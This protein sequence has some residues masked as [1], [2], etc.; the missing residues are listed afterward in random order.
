MKKKKIWTVAVFTFPWKPTGKI[1]FHKLELELDFENE[2]KCR[3]S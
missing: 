2:I 1:V 3:A